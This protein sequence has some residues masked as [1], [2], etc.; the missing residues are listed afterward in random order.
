MIDVST[1]PWKKG[2]YQNTN[3]F[4]EKLPSDIYGL[5]TAT[6][7]FTTPYRLGS[8][9]GRTAGTSF[10][11]RRG[12][13]KV[14]EDPWYDPK[15]NLPTD[16]RGRKISAE[17]LFEDDI[18][19]QQYHAFIGESKS[20]GK[21]FQGTNLNLGSGAGKTTGTG[22]TGTTKPTMPPKTT[23][24]NKKP[25]ESATK[26]AH[27]LELILDTKKI[28]KQ[29]KT[30]QI[31]KQKQQKKKQQQ[32]SEYYLD[33]AF[34]RYPKQTTSPQLSPAVRLDTKQEL[35]PILKLGEQLKEST[36]LEQRFSFGF[37][38]MQSVKQDQSYKQRQNNIYPF[39]NP[40]MFPAVRPAVSPAATKPATRPVIPVPWP[41][42]GYGPNSKRRRPDKDPEK[43]QGWFIPRVDP[44]GITTQFKVFDKSKAKGIT[45]KRFQYWGTDTRQEGLGYFRP[46][47]KG[48]KK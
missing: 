8:G 9:A 39:V 44:L 29:T 24:P 34:L 35:T 6:E 7:F 20:L 5:D 32:G 23:K 17:K 48:S 38:K 47:K 16:R 40:F 27:G 10:K 45:E 12:S 14:E 15:E 26:T 2:T 18:Q 42:I 36:K 11:N 43:D 3:M 13:K 37:S 31:T 21:K 28:S 1:N 33:Y 19:K 22:T 25:D 4:R 41:P 30:K 46:K